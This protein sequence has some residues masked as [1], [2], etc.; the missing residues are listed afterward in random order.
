[1]SSQSSSFHQAPSKGPQVTYEEFTL[2]VFMDKNSEHSKL[3]DILM[4][5]CNFDKLRIILQLLMAAQ[6]TNQ[7]DIR[8]LM[9]KMDILD[10]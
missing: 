9:N 10:E 2:D 1:M 3:E 5:T 7:A 8:T 4:F 6:K